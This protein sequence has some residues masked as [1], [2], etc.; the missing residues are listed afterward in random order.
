[1]RT[2]TRADLALSAYFA[3]PVS[4][5]EASDLVDATLAEIAGELV[6][7]RGK[8]VISGF[9][10]FH[11]HNSPPRMGRN[12]KR[13]AEAHAIPAQSRVVFRAARTS[14]ARA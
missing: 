5:A 4:R 1:M 10:T 3:G 9:G 7:G 6:S 2:I 13:P 12:P 11:V 14:R 8:V